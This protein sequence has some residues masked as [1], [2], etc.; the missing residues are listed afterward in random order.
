ML[1]D[2]IPNIRMMALKTVYSKKKL[3]DK[4]T[5]NLVYKMKDDNDI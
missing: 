2:R 5:E 4:T 3:L 1:G